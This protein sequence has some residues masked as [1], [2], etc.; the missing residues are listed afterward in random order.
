LI[1]YNL[2]RRHGSL[3]H[4]LKVKTPFNAIEKWFELDKKIFNQNPEKFKNIILSL[5]SKQV[6]NIK[7]QPCET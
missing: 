7:Q 5:K 6:V 3:R 4:E 2:Y 1:L